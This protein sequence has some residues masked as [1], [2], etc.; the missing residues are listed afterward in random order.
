[1]SQKIDKLQKEFE[2][3]KQQLEQ[4]SLDVDETSS[5]IIEL[6]KK[7]E[8]INTDI[9]DILK[10]IESLTQEISFLKNENLKVQQRLDE[11]NR[12]HQVSTNVESS[13]SEPQK[14]LTTTKFE[15]ND[16]EVLNKKIEQLKKEVEEVKETQKLSTMAEIKDPNL[17]RILSSPYLV[18][19]TLLI[20]IFALIAAF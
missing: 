20:S 6:N 9:I 11:I 10:K 5:S 14:I 7:I 19:T 3:I 2:L 12:S 4:L 15:L 1:M 16:F 17:R 18:L 8:K 13:E